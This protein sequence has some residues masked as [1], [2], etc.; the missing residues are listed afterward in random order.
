MS[1]Q[2]IDRPKSE[3]SKEEL[4]QLEEFELRHGPMSLINEAVISRTPVIISLR[5]NHKIIAR[6]KAFD[7]HCNMVLENVKELWTEKKHNKTT[8]KER[9]ISKLFLRGDSVII[10]LKAPIE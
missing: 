3:L 5:N 10:I 1:D 8:N 6:V 7:R 4:D 9:F 2:I